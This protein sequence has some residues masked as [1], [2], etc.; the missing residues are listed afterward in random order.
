MTA[1]GGAVADRLSRGVFIGAGR[2]APTDSAAELPAGADTVR[3]ARMPL[4]D[5]PP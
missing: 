4:A 3:Q 2:G 5:S 1:P